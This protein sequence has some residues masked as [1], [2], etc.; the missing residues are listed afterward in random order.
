MGV[1]IGNSSFAVMPELLEMKND[2]EQGERMN[3]LIP[4]SA[5]LHNPMLIILSETGFPGFTLYMGV[6]VSAFLS[7]AREYL[8]QRRL[9]MQTLSPYFAIVI[10][11]F[12]GY[13]IS[14]IKGGGME[15]GFTYFLLVSLLLIPSVLEMEGLERS[16]IQETVKDMEKWEPSR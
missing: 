6:L 9:S 10:S 5:S 12:L 1:G 15:L 8:K 7:F 3:Y 11:V 14:W 16:D 2:W 13:M 4:D